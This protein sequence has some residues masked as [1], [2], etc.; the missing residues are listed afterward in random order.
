MF[1]NTLS[2]YK[3]AYKGLTA[4]TWLLSL[5]MLINRSGTMVLPFMTIYLTSPEMGY[6]I[7]KAG[8]VMAL[9]GLGAVAGGYLGGKVTD[10]LG[11]YPVQLITLVGGG[12]MFMVLGQVKSFPLICLCTFI[13]TLV[14]E[15]FRPANSTAIVAYSREDNRTRSYA[16]NRLAINLGWAVGSAAGGLLAAI[17]YELLFWVDG[18]T[19][20][21][22]ALLLWLF[23]RPGKKPATTTTKTATVPGLSQS[24]Y[25]DTTYLWFIG[26]T[27]LFAICFFQV[28]MNMPVFYKNELHFSE[29][30]IGVINAINGVL[31]ALVEVAL[32]F[33]LE[34]RRPPMYYIIRGVA[35][36]GI[37]FC[38]LNLFHVTPLV[39]VSGVV[40]LT[41]G[42]MLSMP[43]MNTYWIGRSADHNRGQYAGLYTIAWSVAQ[44]AGP[45]LGALVAEHAGFTALWW[46]TGGLCFAVAI[47]FGV[48]GRKEKLKMS[49]EKVDKQY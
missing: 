11:F 25:K 28:F 16:V 38:I 12:I 6:S 31:I 45:L 48:M 34:G 44:T 13:L 29:R 4:S 41:V 49:I 1:A 2:L 33:K 15:A 22:A 18:C 47:G 7:G 36:V 46:A 23:L 19:N 39:A 5:V 9:F 26:L 17:N 21:V 43:F 20:I 3:N 42:E 24:A 37:S 8:I 35:L 10:R 27:I 40:M 32:I 30:L 14:N